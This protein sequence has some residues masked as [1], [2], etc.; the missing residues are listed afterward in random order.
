MASRPEPGPDHAYTR[1]GNTH[2][3]N[4][5]DDEERK[6]PFARV[7]AL[8]RFLLSSVLIDGGELLILL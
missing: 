4:D 7:L 3:H 5:S 1:E 6:S 2:N 8:Q